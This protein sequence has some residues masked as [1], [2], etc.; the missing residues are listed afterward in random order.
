M[1]HTS[2]RSSTLNSKS[3]SSRK[4]PPAGSAGKKHATHQAPISPAASLSQANSLESAMVNENSRPK[5]HEGDV[6]KSKPKT[7]PVRVPR[8]SDPRRQKGPDTQFEPSGPPRDP[9]FIPHSNFGLPPRLP[10]PIGEELHKP[11]SPIFDAQ[12]SS[13]LHEDDV[14]GLLPR[15]TSA[16]SNTTVDDD[17]ELG[18]ELRQDPH[19]SGRR[20]VPTMVCWKQGGDKVYV[21]GTFAGWSRK[22]R[23]TR[24]P[25]TGHLSAVLQLPPGT[26]HVKFI[27][28]GEMQLSDELPTAVDYTNILVNYIEVSADDIPKE[29]PKLPEGVFPPQVLPQGT[30]AKDHDP[31]AV[32]KSALTESDPRAAPVHWGRILPPYLNDVDKPE[33]TNRYQRS[34]RAIGEFPTP[35]GLPLFL[36]KSI[37]NGATPMKDDSSVL[38][39]PNHTVLNHLATSSIK[40]EVLATSITTRYIRKIISSMVRDRLGL[41]ASGRIKKLCDE[42]SPR[43]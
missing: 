7:T 35:P 23:M 25:A 9:N 4:T 14:D 16:I 29:M 42:A 12:G 27:V 33:K 10:L 30:E 38:N 8:G 15:Q 37:L 13:A 18:D 41:V 6:R 19:E 22:F 26:H 24:D 17:D 20:I 11:G 39:M 43:A 31:G 3:S 28:D 40:N 5:E 21:T 34:A 1:H 2:S 32:A 36:G